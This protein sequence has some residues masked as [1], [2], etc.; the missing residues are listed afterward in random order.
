MQLITLVSCIAAVVF[1][2]AIP[3]VCA[4]AVIPPYVYDY[5]PL[6]W[7]HSEDPYRPS[8]LQAQLDNTTPEVNWQPIQGAPSPVTL[9][10][11]DQLNH[12][13][14]TSVYL[15]S[16]KGIAT[17]PQPAWLRGVTPDAQGR[18]GNIIACA[19]V[20]VDHGEGNVD[21]FY[22]YFYAYNKGDKVLGLE[23][24]DHIGDWEHNMVRFANG[25]PQAL[26][27]SQH[28]S[29]QAF[30]YQAVE[31][32]G[33]RPLSYSGNGT[34]ANYAI[35]GQHDHTIPGINLPTG[36]LLDYTDRGVLWDPTLNAWAYTYDVGTKVFTPSSPEIPVAWLDFNGQW[37]DDQPPGEP[38][39]FGEA[40]YVAGPN[41]P[42]FK[43]LNRSLVCP[44]T[45]CIVL[46]FK[47]WAA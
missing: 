29:G 6:V 31:K 22:F 14:N 24:G 37:G 27:Y 4:T 5:A 45:P 32:Q 38:S 3:S 41:G 11:L 44:S 33:K 15:T 23:F 34:H 46:P 20:V 8:D 25:A 36:F 47:I 26:W 19:I 39:I 13:G 28:A 30:T 10:N 12:L 7:L 16:H 21:A 9:D 17:R 35:A 42:K 2:L 1:Q 43:V 18:A 40:E